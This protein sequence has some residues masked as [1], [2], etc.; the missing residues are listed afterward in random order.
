[1]KQ[2]IIPFLLML[3]LNKS[4]AQINQRVDF[5]IQSISFNHTVNCG[6]DLNGGANPDP[7]FILEYRTGS[8]A[9]YTQHIFN[10]LDDIACGTSSYSQ[11]LATYNNFCDEN[12]ELKITAWE[13]NGFGQ[14]FQFNLGDE[15]LSS[16]SSNSNLVNPRNFSNIDTVT[17]TLSG[18]YSVDFKITWNYSAFNTPTMITGN[19]TCR[20]SDNLIS[21]SSNQSDIVNYRWYDSKQLNGY[22]SGLLFIGNN[23]SYPKTNYDLN[24][25]KDVYVAGIVSSSCETELKKITFNVIDVPS[26]PIVDPIIPVC[27]GEKTKIHI[28]NYTLNHTMDVFYDQAML[29]SAGIPVMKDT[30]ETETQ[31]SSKNLYIRSKNAQGCISSLKTVSL[32]MTAFLSSPTAQ[33][34]EI[35]NELPIILN[36]SQSTTPSNFI[37]KDSLGNIL[38]NSLIQSGYDS[39]YIN[40]NNTPGIYKIFVQNSVP[41]ATNSYQCFSKLTPI[42]IKIIPLPIDPNP[43]IEDT[44]CPG[45]SATLIFTPSLNATIAWYKD[46]TDFSPISNGTIFNTP[47]IFNTT[48]FWVTQKVGQ[49][50]SHKKKAIATVVPLLAPEI[51]TDTVCQFE[52]AL[53]QMKQNPIA[54]EYFWYDKPVGGNELTTSRV[55]NTLE[56]ES[57]TAYYAFYKSGRCISPRSLV[58]VKVNPLPII[59]NQRSNTPICEYDTLKLFVDTVVG[60]NYNWTGVNGFVSNKQNP[61]ISYVTENN[62]EG[63]YKII[64]TNVNSGC[65]SFPAFV[66]PIINKKPD[67]IV[68][69]NDGPKCETETIELDATTIIDGQY[70]WWGPQNYSATSQKTK[71]ENLKIINEGLYK[72]QVTL[73]GCKS[74]TI[75]SYVQVYPNPKPNAGKDTFLTESESIQLHASGGIVY[76]WTSSDF[77]D[78][79]NIYNPIITPSKGFHTFELTV[80]DDKGC[81]AKDSINVTV[82]P[83]YLMD[84]RD[85]I[86]PNND[87]INDKWQLKYIENNASHNVKVFARN[88][89]IVFESS[90]YQNDWDGADLPAG[91]YYFVVNSALREYKGTLTIV[92]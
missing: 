20:N 17:I 35:C 87:G 52:K 1:M 81:K 14:P 71:I 41:N 67:N 30:F 11:F 73:N 92:K 59:K 25:T 42:R 7:R 77:F 84:I 23:F 13:E 5:T 48:S 89:Q 21:L 57:T 91:E 6:T 70:Q 9:P 27:Y 32:Q 50:E 10:T 28:Q 43:V 19:T 8:N 33:D 61:F 78:Y 62:H 76:N 74:D 72:L 18:G 40:F 22:G 63:E 26:T 64:L 51:V 24:N 86:T 58:L 82:F 69:T 54:S 88:G 56:L 38:K 3:I 75:K 60:C 79:L 37:W 4:N 12:I 29:N 80:F 2:I 46:S 85:I 16:T 47:L 45:E 66:Y 31:F 68:I 55:Y 39:L 15:N 49:C 53:I 36:A 90:N 34:I 44:T 65:S 83:R